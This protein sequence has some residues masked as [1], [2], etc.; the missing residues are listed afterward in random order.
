MHRRRGRQRRPEQIAFDAKIRSMASSSRAA[1]EQ[2]AEEVR[3]QPAVAEIYRARDAGV[4][5]LDGLGLD[6]VPFWSDEVLRE[7]GVPHANHAKEYAVGLM[8]RMAGVIAPSE[9]TDRKSTRL[10]SSHANI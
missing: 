5:E 8:T 3:S 2:Y 4:L 7:A 1:F 10:N 6:G 9:T